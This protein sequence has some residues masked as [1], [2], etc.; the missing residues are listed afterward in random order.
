[1]EPP[2]E[3]IERITRLA[4]RHFGVAVAFIQW[5]DHDQMW[6][7]AGDA[8]DGPTTHQAAALCDRAKAADG[9]FVVADAHADP[10]VGTPAN[11]TSHARMRFFA[12]VPL[13][14]PGASHLGVL[15][16]AAPSP[17]DPLSSSDE[18]ALADFAALLLDA[19]ETSEPDAPP[20]SES[21]D[22]FQ[23][24]I[25]SADDVMYECDADGVF[26]FVNPRAEE[27]TGQ[28]SEDLIGTHSTELVRDD[29]RTKVR[30][31]YR[32]QIEA[33]E[34][35]SYFEFPIET[36]EDEV[37]W[38]GQN[39]HLV[40][41]DGTVAGLQAV[42][43]DI[44]ASK[45]SERA[46]Q[47]REARSRL[48]YQVT[49]HPTDDIEVHLNY[50]LEQT[51]TLL[52]L[53]VALIGRADVASDRYRVE[54]CYAP[55]FDL[56]TGQTL[57]LSDTYC[58]RVLE[59]G[60]VVSI[61]DVTQTPFWRQGCY[62]EFG[63]ASYIGVPLRVSG[64]YYGTLSFS[65]RDVR[66]NPFDA[67]DHEFVE[68]LG[69]WI[70]S[71][72]ERQR[73]HDTLEDNRDLLRQTQQM[74]QIGGWELDL[75]TYE[76]SWTDEIYRLHDLPESYVPTLQDALDFYPGEARS[77]MR[78]AFETMLDDGTPYDLELPFLT[79]KGERRWVRTMGTIHLRNG[80]PVRAT[81]T[82]QDITERKQA[83]QRL[84]EHQR[85]L[86][87]VINT[88]P[89][90]IFAKDQS[91]RYTLANQALAEA[92][93]TTVDN[94]IGRTD[95]EVSSDEADHRKF[96][97]DDQAVIE[98]G[99]EK[100][101]PE[102]SFVDAEGRTRYLR[103]IKRP[104]TA[105]DGTS[106]QVLGVSVDITEQKRTEAALREREEQLSSINQHISE[107][108]Y[109]S[110]PDEGLVYV[111]E[112][113][114]QMFGYASP[115]AMLEVESLDLYANPQQRAELERME[116]EDGQLRD[117]EVLFRRKDGSTFWGLV[118]GTVVRDDDGTI[119]YYDGAVLDINERKEAEEAL[120]QERDLLD[121][122]MSTSVAAIAVV[123]AAG[124]IIFANSRAES[125]LDLS[126]SATAGQSYTRPEWRITQTDQ[127]QADGA[128]PFHKV[129]ETG[130][131]L[132]GAEHTITWP[133]GRQR[134]LSVNAAP[135]KDDSG[136]VVRVVVSIED[137][138]ERRMA[139]QA[140][141]RSQERFQNLL[142]S[143]NDIVWEAD[144]SGSRLFYLN[145][146]IEHIFGRPVEA[147]YETPQLW[148]Q[149][150]HPDD[151]ALVRDKIERLFDEGTVSMEHRILRPDGEVR[152]LQTYVSVVEGQN[153]RRIGG[154]STDITERKMAEEEIMRTNSILSAQQE[155]AIDGVLVIDENGSV[156]HHNERFRTMWELDDESLDSRESL[157]D[158]MTTRVV[159]PD[160]FLTQ[161]EE[162]FANPDLS[163]RDEI[164]LEDGRVFDRYSAPVRSP[165]GTSY[166][167]VW[168]Y[169]D[170]TERVQ[171]ERKLRRYASD[172]EQAKEALEE[173]SE[174]LANTVFELEEAREQA[175]AATRAK[176]EFLANMS[177]E[178]RTPMNG[179]IGMTTL[180]LETDLN[181]EQHEYAET[182]RTSGDALLDLINDILDFSKIEAGRLELEEHPFRVTQCVEEALDLVAQRAGAK[183]LEL[184]YRIAPDV[185]HHILGDVTRVRQILVNLLSNAVKFTEEGEVIVNVEVVSCEES[186]GASSPLELAFAVHDTGIG[187]SPEKQEQLFESFAQ[188]D[189]S[190]TRK[191]GGTGLG[192]AISK[193]LT[194]MMDGMLTVESEQGEGSTFQFTIRTEA[195]ESDRTAAHQRSE[196]PTLAG[197]RI[198][199]VDDHA[200]NRDILRGYIERWGVD[201]DETGSPED[202][203]ARLNAESSPT[204]DAV[205]LDMLMPSMNG[206]ELTRAIRERSQNQNP[207]LIMLT[208]IGGSTTHR[209]ARAAGCSEALTKPIKPKALLDALQRALAP[210]DADTSPDHERAPSTLDD[211]L[212]EQYPLRILIAEDNLVNQKVTRR[213]LGQLG[214][215]A[216]VVANGQEALEALR[217]Q[218]YDVVL[219]DV[220]MPEMDGMEATRRIIDRWGADR[221][222]VIAMTAAAMEGDRQKCLDAGMDDYV[223]KPVDAE[224][225]IDALINSAS[226]ADAASSSPPPAPSPTESTMDDVLDA[227]ALDE[228]RDAVGGDEAFVAELLS[229]YLTDATTYV[230]DLQQAIEDGHRG[231]L[232]RT[233]HTLKSSSAT[234][235]AET[236]AELNREVEALAR[237]GQLDAAAAKVPAIA[238]EYERVESVLQPLL[239]EMEA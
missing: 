66:Q 135:L 209:E 37:R 109:R 65:G 87:Q 102:E 226:E 139:Q 93:G 145:E 175:E 164:H 177:H 91:G 117:A 211:T 20:S 162:L 236:L 132:F 219:M 176:S 5:A 153:G 178:I 120:L 4:R 47:K 227:S 27:L 116:Q 115:E 68:L 217:R 77:Q 13:V 144:L 32:R 23:T 129:L 73:V 9:A 88:N 100:V 21:P 204:Y 169:R 172:L 62:R 125:L 165:S 229:D 206:I 201:V 142:Q 69:R 41:Q 71:T 76:L 197:R 84:Q 225:L 58:G 198:L 36:A 59:Q 96:R 112:A 89:H 228:L 51:A 158:H 50:A 26:T 12:G 113:F 103:T 61:N 57:T 180:L 114:A 72:L 150:T 222:H 173:N 188:A 14:H 213:L 185:P 42:A 97:R 220:Q 215:R 216:D 22:R 193:Q 189:T 167:R 130:E 108:I 1:M 235:G 161:A 107:G 99:K 233:A 6:C 231:V 83:E 52:G 60:E 212:A 134:L 191:Y 192:L 45:R 195:V 131:P 111:N 55:G 33:R 230:E 81:G 98:S 155:A 210:D 104:L 38:I 126:P 137:I 64:A 156:A 78:E 223:S 54:H 28:A 35:T 151:R 147:F 101:I 43:R 148:Y 138:T 29:Y 17:R 133:D 80:T 30:A 118:S 7:V 92:Y 119:S 171:R 105:D 19:L 123:D 10:L 18:A 163:Q 194:H 237:D 11:G 127:P 181:D 79:A 207:P 75:R 141:Q 121:S 170:I 221:P 74:A 67:T 94:L 146:A 174:R 31:F 208:S 124:E 70:E 203:L 25:E 39:A 186:A 82:I 2:S 48:L 53:D 166:G 128:M 86:R 214:Y 49:T 46:L 40:W 140:L 90:F 157:L 159:D 15:A 56:T 44:T 95:A 232:E 154:L 218:P 202:A 16:L 224:E 34:P 8:S 199:V 238:A 122:I 183:G 63:L 179:V 184:A 152:W 149:A 143:L 110:T 234:F 190:T 205:L 239:H 187:I 182:I 196:L 3:S 200:T 24:L 168:Y 85:F 160:A 136:Q 106:P